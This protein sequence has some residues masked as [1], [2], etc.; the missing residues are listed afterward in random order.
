MNTL[1]ASGGISALPVIRLTV[2]CI[3]FFLNR[4]NT[5]EKEYQLFTIRSSAYI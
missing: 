3:L 1:I 2:L 5:I 4:L